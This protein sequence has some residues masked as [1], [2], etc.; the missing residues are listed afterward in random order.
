MFKNVYSLLVDKDG[1]AMFC[2]KV[3]IV[4][5]GYPTN[6]YYLVHMI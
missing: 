3:M 4:D 6:L 5:T 2:E 1:K